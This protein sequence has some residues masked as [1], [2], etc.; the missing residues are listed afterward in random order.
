[1]T[2]DLRA[3]LEPLS[4][5][6]LLA[7]LRD[8]DLEEWRPEAFPL[9]EAI[10]AARHVDVAAALESLRAAATYVDFEALVEIATFSTSV[11]AHLCRMAL[12]EAEIPCWVF[13]DNLAGVHVPL[14]MAI[15]VSVRVRPEDAAAAREILEAVRSG[16]TA[17]PEDPSA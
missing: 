5:D 1:V 16:A 13:N 8:R 10:L 6:E 7:V 17:G 12:E 4:T 11:D 9:I 15:G 14:G 2:D 3:R